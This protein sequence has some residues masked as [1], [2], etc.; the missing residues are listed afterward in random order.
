MATEINVCNPNDCP[1]RYKDGV[2]F[3]CSIP[4]EELVDAECNQAYVFPDD[5]PLGEGSV[6]VGKESYK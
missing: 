6:N 2:N 3:R 4:Q 1:F 5:C